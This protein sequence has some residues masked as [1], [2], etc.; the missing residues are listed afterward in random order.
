[1]FQLIFTIRLNF[2]EFVGEVKMHKN[3]KL[4]TQAVHQPCN[5]CCRQFSS[6]GKI[7]G[8]EGRGSSPLLHTT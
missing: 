6:V 2:T 1:M 5:N 4:V 8:P 7:V 3:N